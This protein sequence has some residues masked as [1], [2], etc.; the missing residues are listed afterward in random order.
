MV[1]LPLLQKTLRGFLSF[2]LFFFSLSLFSND[3]S[4]ARMTGEQ[5]CQRDIH[6][7]LHIQ[8]VLSHPSI[9]TCEPQYLTGHSD[10]FY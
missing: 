3:N 5:Q 2:F 1:P 10:L 7:P 4:L 9:A 6:R 8:C